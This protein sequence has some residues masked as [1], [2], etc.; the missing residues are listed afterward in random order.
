MENN[1]SKFTR[2]GL[3]LLLALFSATNP[4]LSAG[5]EKCG[6]PVPLEKLIANPPAHHSK[7]LWVVAD[8]TI[9][10]E[11]MTA[12]VPGKPKDRKNCLWLTIDD[13]PHKTDR[14]HARYQ[15][16]LKTWQA[17]SYQTVAIRATFDKTST[18]HFSM[19]PGGLR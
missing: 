10:F 12:C 13:G 2:I 5:A 18:G 7:T 16:K 6:E 4:V 19:W 17:Y 1:M 11:N 3:I 14:D 9:E 8:V 15:T